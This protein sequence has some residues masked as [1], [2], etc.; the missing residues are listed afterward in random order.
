MEN[1]Y[2]VVCTKDKMHHCEQKKVRWA[3]K[4]EE[5][6]YFTPAETDNKATRSM[7]TKLKLKARALKD[8]PLLD[9]YDRRD[10]VRRL[11]ERLARIA[12]KFSGHCDDLHA[13]D[14]NDLNKYWDD[15]FGLHGQ[16]KPTKTIASEFAK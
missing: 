6:L 3:S 5:I 7:L 13:E 14:F 4:L 11:R 8:S 9:M 1:E 16:Y 15:L 2:T 10:L 12:E